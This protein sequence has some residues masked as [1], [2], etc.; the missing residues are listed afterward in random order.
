MFWIIKSFWRKT[1]EYKISIHIYPLLRNVGL[2]HS[3][4]AT[5][6]F[7]HNSRFRI[8]LGHN[9]NKNDHFPSSHLSESDIHTSQTSTGGLISTSRSYPFSEGSPFCPN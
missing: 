9:R 1:A 3:N 4:N 2:L 7:L 5:P 6:Q 8:Y